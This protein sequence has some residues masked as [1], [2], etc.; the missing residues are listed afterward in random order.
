MHRSNV[1]LIT[2]GMHNIFLEQATSATKEEN[3][4]FNN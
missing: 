2:F 3:L 1:K 4:Y